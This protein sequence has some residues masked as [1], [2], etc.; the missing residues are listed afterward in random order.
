MLAVLAFIYMPTT[1]YV[2]IE[3]HAI[4]HIALRQFKRWDARRLWRPTAEVEA[5]AEGMLVADGGFV[6]GFLS[7]ERADR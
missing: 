7:W 1:V 6:Q 5:E 2:S 4:V 3:A